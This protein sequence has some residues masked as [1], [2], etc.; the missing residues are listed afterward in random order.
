MRKGGTT[1]MAIRCRPFWVVVFF[2]VQCSSARYV[3]ADDGMGLMSE[4]HAGSVEDDKQEMLNQIAAIRGHIARLQAEIQQF[5]RKSVP[6][7]G[8]SRMGAMAGPMGMRS[9]VGMSPA[10]MVLS[11]FP[12]AAHLYH[13]GSSDFFLNYSESINLT[14]EQ[15]AAITI[16]KAGSSLESSEGRLQMDQAEGGL[17]TLLAAEPQDPRQIQSKL[18]EI[19]QLRADQRFRF[20]A[21]VGEAAQ[22]LSE[23]QRVWLADHWRTKMNG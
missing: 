3:A 21:R 10:P 20:I 14:T 7:S 2:L 8:L 5:P 12:G 17:M 15:K 19:A 11:G 4:S 1:T 23:T 22:Q 6:G 18:T 16:I 9:E 13:V